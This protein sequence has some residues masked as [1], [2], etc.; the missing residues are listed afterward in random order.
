MH[1]LNLMLGKRN[2]NLY[3]FTTSICTYVSGIYL[4]LLWEDQMGR[5]PCDQH[6]QL[7][8]PLPLAYN[9]RLLVVQ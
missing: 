3:L 1:L 2:T 5:F 9:G 7:K 4:P 6:P 8:N